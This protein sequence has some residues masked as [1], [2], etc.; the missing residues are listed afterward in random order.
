MVPEEAKEED[1][2]KDTQKVADPEPN[3]QQE[4]QEVTGE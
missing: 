1:V 3:Q 2:V 4:E